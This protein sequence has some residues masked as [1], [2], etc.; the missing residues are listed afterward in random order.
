[1]SK[2]SE[3][4]TQAFPGSDHLHESDD[5]LRKLR[6][7]I[8]ELKE[9]TAILVDRW[10]FTNN[11]GSLLAIFSS[12]LNTWWLSLANCCLYS[13]CAQ[14][15]I[16]RFMCSSTEFNSVAVSPIVYTHKINEFLNIS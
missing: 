12:H 10:N 11:L 4:G 14:R 8:A 13:R 2:F 9:E 15:A 3:H 16:A 7:E 5:E 6:K 1:M